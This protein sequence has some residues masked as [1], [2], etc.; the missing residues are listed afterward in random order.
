MAIEQSLDD[1]EPD[2]LTRSI[3]TLDTPDVRELFG[4][5]WKPGSWID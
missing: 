3:R 2:E 1:I 5:G 4:G